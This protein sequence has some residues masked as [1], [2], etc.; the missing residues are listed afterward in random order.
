VKTCC[1]EIEEIYVGGKFLIND[2]IFD[3]LEK[4]GIKVQEPDR[5]YKFISAFDFEAIQIPDCE[6]V[7]GREMHYVHVPATF[8]ICSN[9]PDHTE[10]R[11]V[12]SDGDPQ[13]LVD[14]MVRIQLEQQIKAS[15]IMRNKFEYI[16]EKLRNEMD[17]INNCNCN[18]III[19]LNYIHIH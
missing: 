9:I 6:I 16:F 3:K 18:C 1:T 17:D 8:S 10:T 2:T 12:V 5:Y 11:H 4:V 13:K 7:Y 14:A 15:E 19:H